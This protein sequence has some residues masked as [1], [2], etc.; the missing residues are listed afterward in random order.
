MTKLKKKLNILFHKIFLKLY[1]NMKNVTSEPMSLDLLREEVQILIST[2]IFIE[3]KLILNHSYYYYSK[4][5]DTTLLVDVIIKFLV[6]SSKRKIIY[7]LGLDRYTTLENS[8]EWIIKKIQVEEYSS[9]INLLHSIYSVRIGDNLSANLTASLIENLGIK[10]SN[11]MVYEIFS[12][13]NLSKFIFLKWYTVDYL[14]FSYSLINLKT[15]FYWKSYLESIYS[16][17]KRFSTDTYPLLICTK[18][19]IESKR[20]YNRS[21]IYN[22][23]SSKI[24]TIFSKSLNFLEYLIYETKI[25]M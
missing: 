15:Y 23:N 9:I 22:T 25:G 1:S 20:L 8:N 5:M 24:Q 10:L 21:L 7:R 17:I 4:K 3:F 13:K 11:F 19:G 12:S 18:N 2:M 14:L 16:T 6:V